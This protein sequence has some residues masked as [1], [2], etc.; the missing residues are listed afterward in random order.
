MN[1]PYLLEKQK[2]FWLIAVGLAL[3][4]YGVYFFMEI[5]SIEE[6]HGIVRMKRVFLL[7]YNLGGKYAILALF[8]IVGLITLIA[9]IKQLKNNK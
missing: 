2:L 5:K 3:I 8:E 1:L 7:L 9:G 6:N 4:I